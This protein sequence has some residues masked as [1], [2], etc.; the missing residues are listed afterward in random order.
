MEE[1]PDG[2]VEVDDCVELDPRRSKTRSP[3]GDYVETTVQTKVSPLE[4]LFRL[5]EEMDDEDDEF[6][7]PL[8]NDLEID[9]LVNGN[10][11]IHD[12]DHLGEDN[13]FC[14]YVGESAILC[15]YFVECI[16]Y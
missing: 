8:E 3:N 1:T 9:H 2:V 10:E 12:H 6:S 4:R 11:D 15:Y 13:F 16:S 7:Y 14:N 5:E